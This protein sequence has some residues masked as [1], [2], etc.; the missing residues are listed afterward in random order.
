MAVESIAQLVALLVVFLGIIWH[1]QHSTDK[2]RDE[3]ISNGQRLARIE[4]F[5][6][7]GMPAP[8][9]SG[10]AK[11][12]AAGPVNAPSAPEVETAADG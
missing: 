9:E 5:L 3:V 6:R 2:L 10:G 11:A 1:Q 7:I 4:G 8:A 12:P